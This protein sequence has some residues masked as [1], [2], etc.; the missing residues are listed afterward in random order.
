MPVPGLYAG[1]GNVHTAT[2]L[3]ALMGQI[4][5]PWQIR[6]AGDVSF[7]ELRRSPAILIGGESNV[8][9]QPLTAELRFYFSREGQGAVIRD[10]TRPGFQWP[11]A[12]DVG[13][14]S[15]DYAIVSRILD[16]KTDRCLVMLGGRTQSGT[17]AAG[18]LVTQ[19]GPLSEAM[20]AAPRDW[21]RKNVQLVIRTQV[22]GLTPSSP[23]VLASHVW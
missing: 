16:S 21:A 1:F 23:V 12:T 11:Q 20:K 3:V 22:H 6:T 13:T 8:W 14:K 2:D 15:E 17:Q 19:S 9:T 4:G 10:R 7:A 5:K 18:E